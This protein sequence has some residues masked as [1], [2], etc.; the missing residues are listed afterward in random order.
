MGRLEEARVLRL[1]IG[2]QTQNNWLARM[3]HTAMNATASKWRNFFV[4]AFVATRM[5]LYRI[6]SLAHLS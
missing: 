3:T 6:D 4:K 5:M 2:M 1:F